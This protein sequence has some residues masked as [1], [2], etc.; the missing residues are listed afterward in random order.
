MIQLHDNLARL[1]KNRG[2]TQEA[3]AQFIGVTKASVSKWETGQSF[4]DILILPQLATYFAVSVDDLL[5][6]E[7]NLNKKQIQ[8][9]YHELASE[10]ADNDYSRVIEKTEQLVKKYYACYPF[11]LQICL[12][13]MNHINLAPTEEA[14]CT[15]LL[16]IEQLCEHILAH[17]TALD[18]RNDT[19]IVQAM[20]RLQIG[21]AQAVIE[22]LEP[23][24]NPYHFKNNSDGLLTQAYQA[25][26]H[27]D[28]AYTFSEMMM[29]SHLM[30][31]I[32]NA[33]SYIKLPNSTRLKQLQT[34]ER[35]D[36]LIQTYNI[37]RLH[38]N[39]VAMYNYQIALNALDYKEY[40]QALQRIDKYVQ[41]VVQLLDDNV[42]IHGDD[43]FETIDQWFEE[44]QL[45]TQAVRDKRLVFLSSVQALEV[46]QFV[47]LA[48]HQQFQLLKQKLVKR[49]QR[50]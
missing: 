21:K 35:I 39:T 48:K 8:Q 24:L 20:I 37:H 47:P 26:G 16:R 14:V 7:P 30:M 3:V 45:G 23:L 12:L 22:V 2:V 36:V 44:A 49:G 6:Y 50:L 25:I 11:L 13:W 42:Q 43:Y 34:I 28:Q 33:M 17:E 38:P 15:L 10:F 4:P 32:T 29:Y 40:D 27:Y 9:L 5:G 31:L 19:V 46:A 1:R 41:A 18:V